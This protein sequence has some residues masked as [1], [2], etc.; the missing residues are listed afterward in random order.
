MKT[1]LSTSLR[2]P[3]WMDQHLAEQIRNRRHAVKMTQA[4][5]AQK[6]GVT[7]QQVQKYEYGKNRFS[8]GR[9]WDIREVL[10]VPIEAMFENLPRKASRKKRARGRHSKKYQS[11]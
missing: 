10:D 8:V 4:A 3:N 6:L 7:F 1:P 2:S 9:L 11:V 5:L